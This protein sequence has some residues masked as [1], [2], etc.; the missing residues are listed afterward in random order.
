[1]SDTKRILIVGGVAG[2]ASA[3]ARARRVSEDAQ[4]TL[5]ER[6]KDIS[7]ANCGMPYHVGGSIPQRDR[8]LV[9]TPASF[10][11]RFRVEVRTRCEAVRIDPARHEIVLRDLASERESVEPYDRLILS[12]GAEPIRPAIPGVDSP[13]VFTLRSLADM[14]AIKA[15]VDALAS[16]EN[17]HA[18]IIG[19]GYIGLEMA[20]ALRQRKL[21]VT[22]V[23]L[24]TQVF[25][26][27]DGEMA[28]PIHQQLADQGVKLLLGT[29]VTAIS[30][31]PA[32]P[33][34]ARLAVRLSTGDSITCDLAILAVGVRPEVRLAREAGLA[35][36][37]TGG[38]AVDDHMR[39]SDADI[40]AVGDAVEVKDLVS[41]GP[42]LVPLAGPANRQGRIAADNALGRDS[43]Y[44]STQG[45]AICKVFDLAVG[46]T[47]LSEKALR[48]AGRR[49][50]KVYV[51][52]ASHAGYYPGGAPMSLKLL[53]DPKT[54]GILGAQVVGAEG[55]DKR[56]DVLATAIRAG[57]TV[58][59]LKDLE[60]AYAP[61]YGSARDP[62]NYAGFVASNSL[63][64]RVKLCHW[65]DV[66]AP[67]DG[68]MLLDVRTP[69][70]VEAGTIPGA[71]SIPLDDLRRR[72]GELPK[73]KE[74][75]VF[76]HAGLRGYI[77]C[78]IL[79]QNGFACRNL[80]G[81]YKTYVAA[82]GGPV[83]PSAPKEEGNPGQAGQ[84]AP[85]AAEQATAST[86]KETKDDPGQNAAGAT[87]QIDTRALQCPGPIMRLKA[88]METMLQGQAV[89]IT[90]ADPA[91]PSD[92]RSWCHSTGHELIEVA[93]DNGAFRATIRK[94]APKA[95]AAPAAASAD[96]KHKTIVVF[97]GEFD[98]AVAAFIIANGA[99]SMGRPVTLFFTFWGV[100]VLRRPE[101]AA[102]SKN[103]IERMFG[104][105]M[106]RGA[107]RLKLSRMNMG[108]MGTRMIKGVMRRKRVAAL[109]D[110]IASAR[111][112]GVRLVACAM[113][114]DLM[115]LR[116]E[117]L[118]DGIEEGGVATY[119]A[120][121]ETGN[122]NLFI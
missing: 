4:I 116:K 118:I 2:G 43:V 41:G 110:L 81:G 15:A 77:A 49:Y 71:V 65:E 7:F 60:L 1:M 42:V 45:T 103:L 113:S 100:N 26:P 92:V 40:F 27:L 34:P 74:L 117:E 6:G 109:P 23:E 122:V 47:G 105:M 52:P 69:A 106:P 108:G 79:S 30:Q 57:L 104:W 107:E 75:L 32:G 73:D 48:R 16:R 82:T 120:S 64:G 97:S 3:A 8:L 59:D 68:Q 98:K 96:G 115:G 39:T 84:N 72:M 29:S 55:V 5:I 50:E 102:V 31:Q 121:A 66:A 11:R 13:L 9:Q 70:E 111:A 25:G 14:D 63:E 93:P 83:E 20:E 51:H 17:G 36:G 35:I 99:A 24:A 56:L 67:S 85:S 21:A 76:C 91:F 44:R 10:T 88:E 119:L 78:R 19:G 58:Q 87:K 114:M 46:M 12:P 37:P 89:S 61:P 54:G 38:I 18:L 86:S 95:A 80:T 33:G 90:A 62:I 28:Q 94:A 53:F 101:G 22:L 112:A